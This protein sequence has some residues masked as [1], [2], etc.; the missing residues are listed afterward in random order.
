MCGCGGST[1]PAAPPQQNEAANGDAPA[2][3]VTEVGPSAPGYFWTGPPSYHE[4]PAEPAPA[5]DE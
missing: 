1:T 4:V 5:A 2:P 3:V